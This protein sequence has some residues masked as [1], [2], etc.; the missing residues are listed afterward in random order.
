MKSIVP[1]TV[2]LAVIMN[3]RNSHGATRYCHDFVADMHNKATKK[4]DVGGVFFVEITK[5]R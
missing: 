3:W 5:R 1:P 2:A 4:E